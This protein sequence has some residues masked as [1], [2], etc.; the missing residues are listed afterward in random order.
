MDSDKEEVLAAAEAWDS[1]SVAAP[2]PGLMSAGAGEDY[3]GAAI[4][5][6]DRVQ[7]H[8]GLTSLPS[9]ANNR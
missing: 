1:A 2:H 3:R 5:W 9:T 4:S 7:R 8:H 6:E